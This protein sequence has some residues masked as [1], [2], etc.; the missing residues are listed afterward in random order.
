[1]LQLLNITYCTVFVK[2]DTLIKG[3]IKRLNIVCKSDFLKLKRHF[4]FCCCTREK[5]LKTGDFY[6]ELCNDRAIKLVRRGEGE[7]LVSIVSRAEW[8]IRVGLDGEYTDLLTGK[9]YT[10]SAEVAPDS[11]VILLKN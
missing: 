8:E 7:T 6:A 11:A 10:D 4:L 5:C 3:C 9:K 1:M 2:S